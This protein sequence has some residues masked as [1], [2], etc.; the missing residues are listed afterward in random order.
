MNMIERESMKTG[1]FNTAL[2][3]MSDKFIFAL[4]GCTGK[5]K[6]TENVEYYDTVTNYW[7]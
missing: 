4:G 2:A 3:L 7:H 5:G 6:A 1:R